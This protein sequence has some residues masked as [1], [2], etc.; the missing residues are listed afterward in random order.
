M[1]PGDVLVA[2]VMKANSL[3]GD[4][5]TFS[6]TSLAP[7]PVENPATSGVL[8]S[9]TWIQTAGV[10]TNVSEAVGDSVQFSRVSADASNW[11]GGCALW[12]TGSSGFGTV[13]RRASA[14]AVPS[15]P[16]TTL[17][18]NSA[19]VVFFADWSAVDATTRTWKSINSFIPTAANGGE[20]AYFRDAAQYTLSVVAYPDTGVAGVK[21]IGLDAPTTGDWMFAVVEVRGTGSGAPPAGG[22]HTIATSMLNMAR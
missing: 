6:T 14:G 3:S 12:Y 2:G 20:V 18:D 22:R 17:F 16:V 11:W 19:L 21:T 8:G 1:Q 4:D 10:V 13:E 7:V 5:Y 9:D 15:F